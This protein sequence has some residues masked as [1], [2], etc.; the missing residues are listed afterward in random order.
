MLSSDTNIHIKTGTVGYNNK[1]VISDSKFNLGKNDKVN[2]LEPATM[3]SHKNSKIKGHKVITQST[4]AH[5]D[6]NNVLAQKPTIT[7]EEEKIALIL[8]LTGAFTMWCMFR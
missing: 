1:I 6:P 8:C 7:H 4:H 3:K 5:K 2:A